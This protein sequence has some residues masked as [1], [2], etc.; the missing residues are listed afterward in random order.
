MNKF[1]MHT[2]ISGAKDRLK[3]A[4]EQVERITKNVQETCLHPTVLHW[5]HDA[6]RY[7]TCGKPKRMCP[8]CLRV[9][10]GSYW[11]G[12]NNWRR[13]NGEATSMNATERQVL[14]VVS[15]DTFYRGLSG[16][17]NTIPI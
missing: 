12:I 9:E 2:A 7:G 5:H 6:E 10:E 4:E 1:N 8:V 15:Q 16:K 11:S 14:H 13:D 17:L 3:F